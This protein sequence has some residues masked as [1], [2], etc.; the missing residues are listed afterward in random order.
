MEKEMFSGEIRQGFRFRDREL[1]SSYLTYTAYHKLSYTSC[2]SK[3][4]L[5]VVIAKLGIIFQSLDMEP[6]NEGSPLLPQTSNFLNKRK[7]L[8]RRIPKEITIT[9]FILMLFLLSV[10]LLIVLENMKTTEEVITVDEN[11]LGSPLA[12]KKKSTDKSWKN[13]NNQ[14]KAEKFI[15]IKTDKI[16]TWLEDLEKDNDTE[17][18]QA[19]FISKKLDKVKSWLEQWKTTYHVD[20]FK[21]SMGKLVAAEQELLDLLKSFQNATDKP[22]TEEDLLEILE[23]TFENKPNKSEDVNI[24]GSPFSYNKKA[25]DKTW[26]EKKEKYKKSNK[27]YNKLGY[28]T[29]YDDDEMDSYNFPSENIM[30]SSKKD[31]DTSINLLGSPYSYNKKAFDTTWQAKKDFMKSKTDFNSKK[32][33]S[34]DKGY[35]KFPLL[36]SSSDKEPIDDNYLSSS[37]P[38]DLQ[39]GSKKWDNVD[40]RWKKTSH[41]GDKT[42]KEMKEFYDAW[43]I[44]ENR[45]KTDKSLNHEKMDSNCLKGSNRSVA[46]PSGCPFA[47]LLQSS[48]V[49]ESLVT[50]AKIA[51][52]VRRDLGKCIDMSFLPKECKPTWRAK[53]FSAYK[54]RK[55]DGT[56]NN[57]IHPTW[58]KSGTPFVRMVA[59]DYSD[60]VSSIRTSA[61][62]EALQILDF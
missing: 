34:V 20:K 22:L 51:E 7:C 52:Q 38:A 54:Y 62:G 2:I 8:C 46:A 55:I 5:L 11:L 3:K 24:L 4:I 14:S 23:D 31:P 40:K 39:Y 26:Q 44:A 37:D 50:C 33:D 58:G 1:V 53:C 61:K 25:F 43:K 28:S 47:N 9:A 15:N 16:H 18:K 57:Q 36:G 49:P 35:K 60:G 48:A 12:N 27:E 21:D 42:L 41:L 59:P 45:L 17:S 13:N 6:E 30:D 56:C 19:K 32:W 10:T 29:N